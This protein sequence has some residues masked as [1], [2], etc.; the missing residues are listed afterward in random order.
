MILAPL[1]RFL[2]RSLMPRKSPKPQAQ[3]RKPAVE[4][5]ENRLVPAWTVTN[6]SAGALVA[7]LTKGGTD[8]VSNV[9]FSGPAGALFA[10]TGNTMGITSGIVLSSGV[11]TQIPGPNNSIFGGT[12]FGLPG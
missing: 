10:D 12:G 11:A 4:A 3:S 7:Q 9:T 2:Q 8:I 1:I 6:S 5:L